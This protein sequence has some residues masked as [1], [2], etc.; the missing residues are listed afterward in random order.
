MRKTV[1]I[2]G[3]GASKEANLPVGSEL[4]KIIAS[5]LDIRFEHGNRLISGDDLILEALRLRAKSVD[6]V[7]CDVNPVN[8]YLGASWRIRDAMPQALSID[9]FIDAHAGD[10]KVELTGK[11]AITKAI[12]DAERRS[13]L[14]VDIHRDSLNFNT[15]EDTWYIRLSQLL[16]ENCRVID[17][18]K[19]LSSIA[20]VIFNYDRCVEH[21]LYLALQNYYSLSPTAAADLI[22]S[23]EIYHPYGVVGS[24]PWLKPANAISFGEIPPPQK[25]LELSMSI[26]TFTQG[27]VDSVSDLTAIRSNLKS[28]NGLV[29]LGF[30]FHPM[31]LS[32][33][34]SEDDLSEQ[35]SSS[36]HIYATARGI[37]SSDAKSIS[38]E[39]CQKTGTLIDD[40]DVRNDLSCNE[41]FLEYKRGLSLC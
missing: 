24:L 8:P 2:I 5:V 41:I 30:A 38:I 15:L 35:R 20:L 21:Y 34:F 23:I 12:L 1:F 4:K 14:F 37:S 19:R 32:L 39:L 40:I 16:M 26:K 9:N 17:L 29:F 3:A 31:N 7:P 22:K 10:E 28:A 25:L 33:L 6:T 18:E 36:K 13:R 11:L 27:T